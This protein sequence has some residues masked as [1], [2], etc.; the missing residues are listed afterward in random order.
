[1]QIQQTVINQGFPQA[2]FR[3]P[4]HPPSLHFPLVGLKSLILCSVGLSWSEFGPVKLL[5]RRHRQYLLADR[6]SLHFPILGLI[7][8]SWELQ[9]QQKAQPA[10]TP[11]PYTSFNTDKCR[12]D[13]RF[14]P[15][16]QQLS[17]EM[18]IAECVRIQLA[19]MK[20]KTQQSLRSFR[21]NFANVTTVLRLKIYQN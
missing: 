14:V 19:I 18:L 16:H 5:S 3:L 15:S 12:L 1:M 9:L 21:F 7:R 10:D 2:A 17:R 8:A 11:R 4:A 13:P 6:V 20:I